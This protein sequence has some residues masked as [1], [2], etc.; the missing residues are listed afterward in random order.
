MTT[1]MKE[2]FHMAKNKEKKIKAPKIKKEKAPGRGKTA[3]AVTAFILALVSL[4]GGVYLGYREWR[5]AQDSE[6][7]GQRVAALEEAA[8]AEKN[9]EKVFI[10]MEPHALAAYMADSAYQYRTGFSSVRYD[11]G[12]AGS[13]RLRV[14]LTVTIYN[15]GEQTITVTGAALY[16]W[17]TVFDEGFRQESLAARQEKGFFGELAQGQRDNFSIGPGESQ[18]IEID[19]RLRG[20]YGHPALEAETHS[21]FMEYFSDPEN[22]DPDPADDVA[23]AGKGTMNGRVNYLFCEAL[24]YYCARR[25]TQFTLTYRIETGRGNV[26]SAT[27]AVPF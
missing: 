24:N 13:V 3:L 15:N 2:R 27:C 14:P 5:A 12:E 20:V 6:A 8:E 25:N 11:T 9:L 4:G 19:A 16:P 21:F 7:I 23:V 18:S 10:Q 26:F 22:A 1:P 17:E